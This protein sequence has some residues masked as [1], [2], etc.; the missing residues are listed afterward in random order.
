MEIWAVVVAAGTGSRFGRPKQLAALGDRR[1]IDWSVAAV[2]GVSAGVV[3]VGPPELEWSSSLAV[4]ELVPGGATRSESVRAG[5]AAVPP[6]AS[7]ILVHD[8]AR[9][10]A[11]AALVERVVGALRAGASAAVP[12]VSVTDTLRTVDG[13]PFDRDR[14]VA[15]QTPQGF[16]AEILRRAHGEGVEATDDATIVEALGVT[17]AHV[18]GSPTNL[19]ITFPHDLAVAEALLL[20]D[21]QGV[22]RAPDIVVCGREVER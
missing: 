1:V 14:L 9:P 20:A 3:A 17:V 2:A 19:K 11:T 15:V 22:I 7:H 13:C 21:G 5:L 6:S 16:E 18:A 10:L 8:A 12:V 4:D